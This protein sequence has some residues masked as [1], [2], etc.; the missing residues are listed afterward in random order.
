MRPKNSTA[1]HI[2]EER[3]QI[4]LV[5]NMYICPAIVIGYMQT[6][7]K[8]WKK[9]IGQESSLLP[10]RASK[11]GE[12]IGIGTYIICA[13]SMDLGNPWIALDKVW[14]LTLSGLSMDCPNTK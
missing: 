12:V 14:I 2:R 11:Q 3:L 4:T 6:G 5:D 13:Q 10:A 9:N 7:K 8:K 1:I